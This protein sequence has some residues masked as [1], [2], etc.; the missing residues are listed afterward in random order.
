VKRI[1]VFCGSSSGNADVFAEVAWRTGRV[2][3]ERGIGLVYGG[4]SVGLMGAV[5]GGALEA[6]GEVIGVIPGALVERERAGI[7]ASDPTK[8][9]GDLRVVGSM[10]ERKQLM[11][12]L[13]D[14]FIA[15]PGGLGTLEELLETLTWLQLGLHG[16]PAGV[17][18]VEGYFD[19]L[20]AMFDR[21]RDS[22]LLRPEHHGLLQ[23]ADT[24]EGLLARFERWVPPPVQRYIERGQT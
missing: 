16:K 15:L 20:L 3:A 2:L 11:H 9:R 17:V 4:G 21:A 14:G 6:G 23:V 8:K 5:S 12:D 18:S 7:S 22:G 1:C 10:H 24:P 19:P 13:S